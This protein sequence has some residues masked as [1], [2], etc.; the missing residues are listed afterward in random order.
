MKKIQ[1]LLL[2]LIF[3]ALAC[4]KGKKIMNGQETVDI[5]DFIAFF[6]EIKLPLVITDSLLKA[7]AGDSTQISDTVFAQFVSDT[8]FTDI[9][10]RKKPKIFALG[11]FKNGKDAET[12]LLISTKGS[13]N[14]IYA[15][16]FTPKEK[17][18][19]NLLLISDSKKAEEINRVTIDPKYTFNLVDQYKTPDGST[20]E[21]SQVYAYN[22]AGIFTM[23][24]QDGLPKGELLP[25]L[26]PIDTL[27]AAH[28]FSGDYGKDKRNF[29]T[30]RDGKTDK[31]F[32]FFINMDK[33]NGSGCKAELKGEAIFITKDSAV[34]TTKT[35][36]CVIGFRFGTNNITI[37]EAVICGN[38]RPANCSFN[39]RYQKQKPAKKDKKEATKKSNK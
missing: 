9:Y 36:P 33:G 12:Y 5:K 35:D 31:D 37:N 32:L 34:Y 30:V 1:W 10:G 21:F 27:P 28:R 14:A 16:A 25:I 15:L 20:A 24:L 18:S 7:K 4:G 26:N 13:S 3:L 23:I 22:N 38:K 39:A 19:A 8:V 29:I 17:Y 2:P 6:D 11:R